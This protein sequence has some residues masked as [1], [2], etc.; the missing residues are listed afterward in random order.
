MPPNNR[1]IDVLRAVVIADGNGG[2]ADGAN[3]GVGGVAHRQGEGF[4]VFRV[5]IIQQGHGEGLHER[6]GVNGDG[7]A[8]GGVVT[9]SNGRS[10]GTVNIHRDG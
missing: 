1:Q 6:A 2:G 4:V 7:L 8:D 3:S 9:T 5:T 10:V